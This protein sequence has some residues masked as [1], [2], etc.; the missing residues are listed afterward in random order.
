MP[1][2][3]TA[4]TEATSIA[5]N[6]LIY[7]VVGGNSRRIT[8]A[9]LFG[10]MPQ[11]MIRPQTAVSASGI[12]VDFTGIPTWANRITVTGAGLSTNGTANIALRVGDGTFV[13]TGY[14]GAITTIAGATPATT[15]ITASCPLLTG[16][17][18]AG[19]FRFTCTITRHD[20][21]TWVFSGGGSLSNTATTCAFHSEITLSGALDRVRVFTA[22]ATD[23]FDL[24]TLAIAWE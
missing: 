13:G 24:G 16:V 9:N 2:K 23:T 17:T 18:A 12:Q 21:N 5:A 1:I 14:L 6:S 10:T 22:N 4:L 15:N 11:S 19:V 8:A 20:G 3:L 7:A